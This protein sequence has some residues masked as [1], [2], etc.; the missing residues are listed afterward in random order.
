MQREY[1]HSVASA[2]E[3]W[4]ERRETARARKVTEE[5]RVKKVEQ[6]LKKKKEEPKTKLNSKN[7]ESSVIAK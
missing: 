6:E 2:Q 3:E 5:H 4:N 7:A 1:E